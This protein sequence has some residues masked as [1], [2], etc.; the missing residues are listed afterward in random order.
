MSVPPDL[1]VS[2][3]EAFTAAVIGD[4]ETCI[5]HL[6]DI[7]G[8]GARGV[9]IACWGWSAATLLG[10]TGHAEPEPGTYSLEIVH[11]VTGE[12]A[13]ID[14]AVSEPARR[15]ALQLVTLCANQDADMVDAVVRA[16]IKRDGTGGR[17]ANGLG[18]PR[19][20][21]RERTS[22]AARRRL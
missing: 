13:S 10:L 5:E 16:H 8:W 1:Q 9:F 19:R 3:K 7:A 12:V 20:M 6:A 15:A 17:S 4:R 22:P 18:E 14:D 2:T 21:G 11:R